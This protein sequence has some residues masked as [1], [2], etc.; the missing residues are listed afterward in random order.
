MAGT[1]VSLEPSPPF[2]RFLMQRTARPGILVQSDWVQSFESALALLDQYPWHKL[3]R[4]KSIPISSG[5]H[6]RQCKSDFAA[7]TRTGTSNAGAS[8]AVSYVGCDCPANLLRCAGRTAAARWYESRARK[9]TTW[10]AFSATPF[11]NRRR[12]LPTHPGMLRIARAS[13]CRWPGAGC[14]R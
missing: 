14:V 9:G 11:R 4:Y 6:G 10:P 13:A 1:S 2:A 3:V 8:F 5:R 7:G 12:S